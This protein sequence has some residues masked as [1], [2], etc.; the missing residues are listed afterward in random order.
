MIFILIIIVIIII[1]IYFEY[2]NNK[3]YFSYSS[4]KKPYLWVYW[5]LKN[6]AQKP[7]D[8]IELCFETI[9][10][11]S[12]KNFNLIFLN[13]KTIFNYLSSLRKDINELPI[14]L[15]TDYIRVLLLEKYG[16]L[17]MDADIIM[18]NPLD[19][20]AQM[21]NNNNKIDFIGFGCTG[22]KCNNGYGRPSN[23]L[24]GS[25]INGKLISKCHKLLDKKL[26]EY[27]NTNN[28]KTFNYHELGKLTIWEAYDILIKEEPN[29]KYH[30]INSD[31]DGSRDKNQLWVA[32]EIIFEK[33]IEYTNEDKLLVVVLANSVYCSDDK[34]YNWFCNLSKEKI[35]NGKYMISK[36]F[37]KA[38]LKN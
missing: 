10:K 26:D 38:L 7:P 25:N 3:E 34:K 1:L 19:E 31:F 21:L 29:Y 2:Y 5:E 33:N 23:W 4:L 24:M 37:H 30:H 18:L 36:M 9:K 20:I 8:Y 17:W 6:G 12:M 32:P 14:A 13:E 16:G 15:K 27:F 11:N 22:Y 35:L 28:K